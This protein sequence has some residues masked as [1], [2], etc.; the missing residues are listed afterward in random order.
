MNFSQVIGRNL[1]ESDWY[2][3]AATMLKE[4]QEKEQAKEDNEWQNRRKVALGKLTKE[5]EL[6]TE[7]GK[8][9]NRGFSLF[10][11]WIHVYFWISC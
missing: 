4:L 8:K 9:N 7:F 11:L 1:Y 10:N 6:L 2:K 3:E 5:L